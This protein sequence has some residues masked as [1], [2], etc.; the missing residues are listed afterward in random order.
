MSRGMCARGGR[1]EKCQVVDPRRA[2][3]DV[4]L[5]GVQ[6]QLNVDE[7]VELRMDGLW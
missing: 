1:S 7:A 4:Q 3:C 2:E 6:V 5:K